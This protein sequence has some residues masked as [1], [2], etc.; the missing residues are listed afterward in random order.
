[1]ISNRFYLLSILVLSFLL[2]SFSLPE[3]LKKKVSK[4]VK[5]TFG[6]KEF[7]LK[8]LEFNDSVKQKLSKRI[9]TNHLFKIVKENTI[10]GYAYVD[11][12]PSKTDEFDYLI[13]LNKNLFENLKALQ[14]RLRLYSFQNFLI[15]RLM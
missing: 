14:F 3:K 10:L 11:K 9:N 4:E 13:L 12:A 1:M 8:T 7:E 6:I 2:L 15:L 5:I